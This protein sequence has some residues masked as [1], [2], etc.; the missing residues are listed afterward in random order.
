MISQLKHFN[1][2]TAKYR[3]PI[4]RLNEN[5]L[6]CRCNFSITHSLL[7]IDSSGFGS[8]TLFPNQKSFYVLNFSRFSSALMFPSQKTDAVLITNY[9]FFRFIKGSNFLPYSCNFLLTSVPLWHQQG[10]QE[11]RRQQVQL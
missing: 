5:N 3:I 4:A 9:S 1:T 8:L 7:T 2:D 6:H 10:E 11:M